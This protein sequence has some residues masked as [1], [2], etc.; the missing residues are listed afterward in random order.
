MASKIEVMTAPYFR[1]HL[2]QPRGYGAWAFVA[3][4]KADR[5]GSYVSLDD[6]VWIT[7]CTYGEAKKRLA[8]GLWFAQP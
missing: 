7:N 3:A 5:S 4:E 6:V 2:K 8:P 1:S